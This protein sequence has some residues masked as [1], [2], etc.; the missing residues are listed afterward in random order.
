[1]P[2]F[3]GE[4]Y[5][6]EAIESVLMQTMSD[7]ELVVVDDGSV[8]SSRSIVERL[9]Q[10]DSRVR[11]VVNERNLGIATALYR[12]WQAA[13]S[14]LIARLDADDVALPGRLERQAA[15]LDAHPSVAVVGGAAHVVDSSGERISTMRFPTESRVIRTTLRRHNCFAHPTVLLRR[16]ALEDVGG[17]RFDH[18]EDY[19]LWLRLSERFDLAN[20]A[21][22]LILYRVH[23]SQLSLS[24]L[25]DRVK[26]ALAVRAA[27][28]I[29]R[30]TGADPLT[31]VVGLTAELFDRL[32]VKDQDLTRALEHEL[33]SWANVLVDLGQRDQAQT[34]LDQATQRF[35]PRARRAY[36]AASE[37][38]AAEALLGSG[39]PLAGSARV[40]L[41]FR[42]EPRYTSTR[43]RAWLADHL[44]G[45]SLPRG[46]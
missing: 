27:A 37:L 36:A 20:L 44:D 46:R 42:H 18:S 45:R 5:L 41:A 24:D 38:Q 28:R 29:R 4:A 39:H 3:N 22:P 43:L 11:L 30:A 2:V 10:V 1:M 8:D 12:G 16:T 19:D 9:G 34:L 7:L 15:F 21:E 26:G 23:G 17:Y 40:L 33:L 25:E 6:A 31:G 35:G 13:R 14:P 32:G